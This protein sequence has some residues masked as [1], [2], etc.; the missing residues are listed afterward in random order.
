MLKTRVITA[1]LL[2]AGFAL[3]L[4]VLPPVAAALAFAA[5]AALAAWEWGGLMRQ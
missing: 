4:F 1:L 2:A 3:V 5:I